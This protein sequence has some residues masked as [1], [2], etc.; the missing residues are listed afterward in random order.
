MRARLEYNENEIVPSASN[1]K[2]GLWLC[3]MRHKLRV[4]QYELSLVEMG[5]TRIPRVSSSP[6]YSNMSS[7]KAIKRALE[8]A[9]RV[10]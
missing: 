1:R 10:Y 4:V 5:S 3:L 8:A 2:A 9:A 6:Y 7:E